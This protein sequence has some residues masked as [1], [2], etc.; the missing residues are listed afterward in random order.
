[1]NKISLC[2]M[3]TLWICSIF[4]AKAQITI[5]EH[6]AEITSINQ[7]SD[8]TLF[9]MKKGNEYMCFPEA[10]MASLKDLSSA[11]S[12]NAF[13]FKLE[14]PASTDQEVPAVIK[15]NYIIRVLNP[16]KGYYTPWGGNDSY[17]NALSWGIV[18]TA[19]FPNGNI[20]WGN[21]LLYGGIWDLQYSEGNGWTIKNIGWN[22]YMNN[23][24]G[25]G[26]NAEYWKL[27][28]AEVDINDIT[29]TD[30]R[31]DVAEAKSILNSKMGVTAKANLVN[32][33]PA[34]EAVTDA[35]AKTIYQTFHPILK[36]AKESMLF[37]SYVAPY[38]GVEEKID[39]TGRAY[40]RTTGYSEISQQYADGTLDENSAGSILASI[41]EWFHTSGK[42]Q[43]TPGSSMT[44]AIINPSFEMGTLEGWTSDNGGN[45]PDNTNFPYRT[46]DKFVERWTW[47]SSL[48]D[49]SLKQTIEGLPNGTYTLTAEMQNVVQS[50]NNAPGEGYYL[51]ANDDKTAVTS[52]G[53]TVSV[54]TVVRD[55]NLTIGALIDKC[56]GNWVCVDNFQL[57]YVNALEETP[58]PSE[59][60]GTPI[61]L[62]SSG[63]ATL[64]VGENEVSKL[65]FD[66]QWALFYADNL[67]INKTVTQ[68][69]TFEFAEPAPVAFN[70]VFDV[71]A[72]GTDNPD[73]QWRGFDA[74]TTNFTYNFSEFSGSIIK[75]S[76]VNTQE[77]G[78]Q[79]LMLKAAYLTQQDGTKTNLKLSSDGGTS[80]S[81][82]YA[83]SGNVAFSCRWAELPLKGIENIEEG[84]KLR[85]YTDD[86]DLT[87]KVQFVVQYADESWEWPQI[88]SRENNHL[89]TISRP[90]KSIGLQWVKE[91]AGTIN[92]KAITWEKD[93][94]IFPGI[95]VTADRKWATYISQVECSVPAGLRAFTCDAID[96]DAL[97]LTEVIGSI[98]ANT[99]CILYNP[100]AVDLAIEKIISYSQAEKDSYTEGLL[101]GV[102]HKTFVPAGS[103]ILQ[104]QG[105]NTGFFICDQPNTNTVARN[106]CYLTVPAAAPAPSRSFIFNEPGTTGIPSVQGSISKMMNGSDI[107][108][109]QGRKLKSMQKGI[110]IINGVKV[111]IK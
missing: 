81:Y 73:A 106:R 6:G 63:N 97:V 32:G 53:E 111:R 38:I 103:Y 26:E 68:S 22:K 99:P 101:T 57:T 31:N 34:A 7:I 71:L 66:S 11:S 65:T 58:E 35:N 102:Y 40:L 95:T 46:G 90:V 49:G 21:D 59:F 52:H 70:V 43:R 10:H 30:V 54:T 79:S 14:T 56:T 109:A 20:Q 88:G 3:V 16:S 74:G 105:D 96:G 8:G 77:S 4:S 92:I 62:A 93:K 1:M 83:T 55:G 13:Y 42:A 41:K 75:I 17:L 36:Q 104:R 48:S 50:N 78:Q 51:V 91:E 110:N 18:T 5:Y 28:K 45:V 76:I 69:I 29:I 2:W 86:D 80:I 108:D 89:T 72:D 47:E 25:P 61:V 27:Y 24:G 107:Y 82:P 98:P 85:I 100:T 12:S 84:L 60:D 64:E 39:G 9:V 44:T 67:N 94:E 33:L 19:L 23:A 37:Y 15:D 87:G